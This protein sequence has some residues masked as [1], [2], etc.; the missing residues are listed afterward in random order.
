MVGISITKKMF[1]VEGGLN[2][3][4]NY[5]TPFLL[6]GDQLVK[7]TTPLF[8][9]ERITSHKEYATPLLKKSPGVVHVSRQSQL[10][11]T[12]CT[13]Q[14]P[15]NRTMLSGWPLQSSH[16]HRSQRRHNPYSDSDP[17]YSVSD[18]PATA[19]KTGRNY[20]SGQSDVRNS[21]IG[22]EATGSLAHRSSNTLASLTKSPEIDPWPNSGFR[23][24]SLL[25]PGELQSVARGYKRCAVSEF[26][27]SGE[28]R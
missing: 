15:V 12:R 3:Q 23:P 11:H 6:R 25:P 17:T 7:T 24:Q 1:L 21:T 13:L 14:D 16:E 4:K 9:R 26:V 28:A 10:F 22:W 8:C 27:R 20:Q 19:P 5:A 18:T 2:S